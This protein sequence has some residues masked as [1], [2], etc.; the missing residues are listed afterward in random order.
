MADF[1]FFACLS[2]LLVNLKRNRKGTRVPD[3]KEGTGTE[4]VP[5][6]KEF[7]NALLEKKLFANFLF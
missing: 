2:N 4:R 7:S 1:A 3:A 6:S 5:H